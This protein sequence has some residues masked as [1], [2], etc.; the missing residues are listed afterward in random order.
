MLNGPSAFSNSSG[1]T[2]NVLF[3]LSAWIPFPLSRFLLFV[4][5][6]PY[7]SC[8]RLS[9]CL[10][11]LVILFLIRKFLKIERALCMASI[12]NT[13]HNL[14]THDIK[15]LVQLFVTML[16]FQVKRLGSPEGHRLD[17]SA[18]G[19]EKECRL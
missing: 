7:F 11:I 8:L 17:T 15:K 5:V 14:G 13:Q 10:L 9:P 19:A 16:I 1:S 4:N 18:R 6:S 2:Y 3:Q 12:W